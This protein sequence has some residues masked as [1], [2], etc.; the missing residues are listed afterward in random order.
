M[1]TMTSPVPVPSLTEIT[2]TDQDTV[3]AFMTQYQEV[4]NLKVDNNHQVNV[5]Q[6]R[7]IS[8]P[9]IRHSPALMTMTA[10]IPKSVVI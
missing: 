1:C 8:R 2:T 7:D 3:R 6:F 9:P 10:L 4:G 5:F